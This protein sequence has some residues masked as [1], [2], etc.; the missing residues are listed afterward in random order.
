MYYTYNSYLH[1]IFGEK[2]YKVVV[3]SGLSCPTRDGS[4]S[5]GG[6]AFCDI[7]GSS[8][9]FGKKGRGLEIRE[10]IKNR[11]P[12]IRKRFN[13]N[14]F[15][16]YFQSY[17][18]T[19]SDLEY[20]KEIYQAALSEPLIEGLCIGTRPD[21]IPDQVLDLLQEIAQTRYISLELGIQSFENQTLEWLN[22]GHDQ[23][24]SLDALERIQ[25]RAPNIHVCAHLI[26]GSP[27]DSPHVATHAAHLLNQSGVKGAKLHQLMVLKNTELARRW[28]HRPFPTLSLEEYSNQVAS[29]IE[30]LSP[31]IYLERLCA[32]ATHSEECLSPLWSCDR[33]MPHNRIRELL[34]QRNCIQGS[35]LGS[36]EN[37]KIFC[38][39]I[40]SS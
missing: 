31:E 6:C 22:R 18:N 40:Q 5:K 9:F 14:R 16:A 27:T 1:R 4:L 28:F 32:T 33:W 35:A 23:R 24:C 13:A 17:T 7:R 36:S 38:G 39:P 34:K 30:N 10:Q 20:L 26:F 25:K 21:C 19:Y 37:P 12:G 3:A 29:F 11:I 8:S 2:T 15:L